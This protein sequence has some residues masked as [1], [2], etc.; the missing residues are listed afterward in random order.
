MA[1]KPK[2]SDDNTYWLYGSEKTYKPKV[3]NEQLK[4]AFDGLPIRVVI[5]IMTDCINKSRKAE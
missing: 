1:S 3:P 2:K 5:G 4:R